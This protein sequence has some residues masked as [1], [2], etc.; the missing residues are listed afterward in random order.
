MQGG[1]VV[2]NKQKETLRSSSFERSFFR[3]QQSSV[4]TNRQT[5][6]P[7]SDRASRITECDLIIDCISEMDVIVFIPHDP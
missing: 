1:W 4:Q 3:S 6:N 7:I 5:D 2:K